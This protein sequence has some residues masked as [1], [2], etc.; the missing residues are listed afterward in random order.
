MADQEKIAEVFPKTVPIVE[1]GPSN[2]YPHPKTDGMPEGVIGHTGEHLEHDSIIDG[3]KTIAVPHEGH[4]Q[5]VKTIP[6]SEEV[7]KLLKE[8]TGESG[9]WLGELLRIKRRAKSEELKAAA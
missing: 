8:G 6:S 4:G 2:E 1:V 5:Q 9:H 7:E 3:G